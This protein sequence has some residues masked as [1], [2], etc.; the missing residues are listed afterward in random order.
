MQRACAFT[1][2]AMRADDHSVGWA[3]PPS[4]FSSLFPHSS[5]WPVIFSLNLS[6]LTSNPVFLLF[7]LNSLFLTN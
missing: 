2:G 6:I 5:F 4:S 7:P 1:G 3:W